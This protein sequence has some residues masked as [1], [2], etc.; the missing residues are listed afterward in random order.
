MRQCGQLE[1]SESIYHAGKGSRHALASVTSKAHAAFRMRQGA[2]YCASAY[3]QV[4]SLA[5]HLTIAA[6][7]TDNS[8]GLLFRHIA[9][10]SVIHFSISFAA[11][12]DSNAYHGQP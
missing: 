12:F 11:L 7:R 5:W 3:R 4:I 10:I 1:C 9:H 8:N 6:K 2:A